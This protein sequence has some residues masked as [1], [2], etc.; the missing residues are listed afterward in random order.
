MKNPSMKR[1]LRVCV[2]TFVLTVVAFGQEPAQHDKAEK[3][4]H[5]QLVSLIQTATTP[6]DHRRLAA[7]YDA[8]THELLAE[9]AEHQEMAEQFRKNGMMNNQKRVFG[10]V[11]HCEYIAKALKEAAAKMQGMAQM[12]EAMVSDSELR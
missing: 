10:T 8:R 2:T 1:L 12:Q 7:Y 3:L 11:N 9:S 6:D 4:G 5:K